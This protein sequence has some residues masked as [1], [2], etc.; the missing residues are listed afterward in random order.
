M[1]EAGGK[2]SA[3]YSASSFGVEVQCNDVSSC[4]LYRTNNECAHATK[5]LGKGGAILAAANGVNCLPLQLAVMR[6]QTQHTARR[7]GDG[8]TRYK[9]RGTF[10]RGRWQRITVMRPP[11]VA[12]TVRLPTLVWVH[13][14]ALVAATVA[15]LL[16]VVVCPV[17]RVRVL[18]HNLL[19]RLLRV[20]VGR[21]L[22]QLLRGWELGPGEGVGEGSR[23]VDRDG[24][25]LA[26]GIGEG[27][28]GR[29]RGK[30]SYAPD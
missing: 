9:T 22:L 30:R 25:R 19:G 11:Y 8:T 5:N 20:R 17:L 24:G 18:G 28:G 21:C 7:F 13:R 29:Q 26:G 27:G 4:V 23:G 6:R 14:D 16:H 10:P 2:W 15:R 3:Y 1:V 12:G